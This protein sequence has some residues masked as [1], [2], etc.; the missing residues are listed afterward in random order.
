[1][2]L[3]REVFLFYYRKILREIY[4]EFVNYRD[5]NIFYNY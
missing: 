5:S 1:M 3:Y 4:L 2:Y